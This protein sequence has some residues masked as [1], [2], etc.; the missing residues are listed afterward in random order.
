M[1]VGKGLNH[2]WVKGKIMVTHITFGNRQRKKGLNAMC[3]GKGVKP[4]VG[5]G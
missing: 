1:R 4:Q 2:K 5:K 3:M